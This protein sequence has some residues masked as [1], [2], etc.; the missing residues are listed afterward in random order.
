MYHVPC[1][2][3]HGQ[4]ETAIH[5]LSITK[6]KCDKDLAWLG[7]AGQ[8]RLLWSF[9]STSHRPHQEGPG[10]DNGG[11]AGL[12]NLLQVQ[13]Q[14]QLQATN[15]SASSSFPGIPGMAL[16]SSLLQVIHLAS[17]PRALLSVSV[18]FLPG[19]EG[20]HSHR[21]QPSRHPSDNLKQYYSAF[22]CNICRLNHS[23]VD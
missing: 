22:S 10:A 13:V 1:T 23:I 2:K 20:S 12:L 6:L 14:V 9:V 16:R 4:A 8:A 11:K 18:L 7:F 15:D 3:Y 19:C 5:C 17:G 21:S